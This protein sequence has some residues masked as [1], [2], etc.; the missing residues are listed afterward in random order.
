MNAVFIYDLGGNYLGTLDPF[1]SDLTSL[2]IFFPVGF[3]LHEHD[4]KFIQNESIQELGQLT[5]G[6]ATLYVQSICYVCSC[7]GE[8]VKC[9]CINP[10][11]CTCQ[12]YIICSSCENDAINLRICY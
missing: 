11:S 2:H 3:D 5:P 7:C 10:Q 9:S 8:A 1:S 12:A 4:V 6:S